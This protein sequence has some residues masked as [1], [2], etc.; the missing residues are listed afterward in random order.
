[1]NSPKKYIIP[2]TY[3]YTDGANFR[4]AEND[5]EVTIAARGPGPRLT[6]KTVDGRRLVV[7]GFATLRPL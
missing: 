2:A 3:G 7:G 1:M 5:I 4:R 6:V